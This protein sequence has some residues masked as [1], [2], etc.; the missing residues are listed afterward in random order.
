MIATLSKLN[1]ESEQTVVVNRTKNYDVTL[2]FFKFP[3]ILNKKVG[4]FNFQEFSKLCPYAPTTV[5]LRI[6]PRLGINLPTPKL[7]L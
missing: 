3:S 5:A 6:D 2:F 4:T 1:I 7:E